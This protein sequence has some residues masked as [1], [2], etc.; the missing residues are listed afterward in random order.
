M[1][2]LSRRRPSAKGARSSSPRRTRGKRRRFT[3]STCVPPIISAPRSP[4]SSGG[5]RS[6]RPRLPRSPPPRRSPKPT[7]RT[8]ADRPSPDARSRS[9]RPGGTTSSWPDP[10]GR[11]RRCSRGVSR[12]SCLR[13]RAR[14]AS[15]SRA[16]GASR[17]GCPRG[18]GCSSIVRSA[19]PITGRRPPR[20]RAAESDPRPGELSL[21]HY[22]VLFL[23]ELPEF[24]RDALEAL[25]EPLEDGV[26]SVARAAGARTF[27]A[28]FLFVAAMNP[29]P[30][31]FR[32]DPRR[33]CSCS[34]RDVA[35]YRRKIS[36]PLARPDRPARR[37]PR[38]LLVRLRRRRRRRAHERRAGAASSPPAR[39]SSRVPATRAS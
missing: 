8:C 2:S 34:P 21:A 16:S 25:R 26:V 27:P 28:R 38:P 10:P 12:A 1:S 13:S 18:A 37:G 19:P 5:S 11:G 9:P 4:T 17:A 39:G 29:C 30:C 31:G 15:R 33:A 14:R 24:R 7:S 20:S 32:G 36:G 22:G 23:D 35:R 6:R 3:A